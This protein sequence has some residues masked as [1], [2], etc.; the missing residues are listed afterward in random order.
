MLTY[1]DGVSDIDI[2]S[3]A[4]YHKIIINMLHLLLLDLPKNMAL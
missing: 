1:G 2:K 3:I 4:K